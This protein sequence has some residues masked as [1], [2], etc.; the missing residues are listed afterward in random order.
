MLTQCSFHA[1]E[2]LPDTASYVH[3]WAVSANSIYIYIATMI[4]KNKVLVWLAVPMLF[5]ASLYLNTIYTH[6]IQSAYASYIFRYAGRKQREDA[7][8]SN[9]GDQLYP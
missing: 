7:G 1:L 3:E 5:K 6:V 8:Y 9:T 4:D 2:A